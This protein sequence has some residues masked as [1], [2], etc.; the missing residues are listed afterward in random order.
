M[1]PIT[2]LAEKK[3]FIAFN[4]RFSVLA[5]LLGLI[6][7]P[8]A[9]FAMESIRVNYTVDYE[10]A[11]TRTLKIRA[12]I[13]GMPDEEIPLLLPD[14]RVT[15]LELFTGEEEDGKQTE[16][17]S[18]T[19]DAPLG[20]N[21][22]LRGNFSETV[23]VNY[24]IRLSDR[25]SSERHSYGDGRRCIIYAS[26]ILLGFGERE[27]RAGIF[28][29][30]PPAWIV[31]T[32]A[33]NKGK[34]IFVVGTRQ[35]IVFYLG[36][37]AGQQITVGQTEVSLAI[38][39]GWEAGREEILNSLRRQISYREKTSKDANI[40]PLFI[41]LLESTKKVGELKIVTLESSSGFVASASPS[42]LTAV[43]FEEKFEREASKSLIQCFFPSLRNPKVGTAESLILEYLLLKT[44]VKM[45]VLSKEQFLQKIAVGFGMMSEEDNRS[46]K[47]LNALPPKTLARVALSKEE[48]LSNLFLMDLLLGFYGRSTSSLEQLIHSK[49]NSVLFEK[50]VE[51][52]PPRTLFRDSGFLIQQRIVFPKGEVEDIASRLKPFGLVFEKR[53]LADLSFDLNENFQIER[54]KKKREGDGR[55][56]LVGDKIIAIDNQRILR[57]VDLIFCRSEMRPGEEITLL[58]ERN[59]GVQKIKQRV[60][61]EMFVR[62]EPNRLSDLDKQEKLE[63]FWSREVDQ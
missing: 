47:R 24:Q 41:A 8:P 62:L 45:G 50:L 54:I 34:G 46:L 22:L 49:V 18:E 44:D 16:T 10:D 43:E 7:S 30:L 42:Y 2:L 55:T 13:Q 21:I 59:G 26:D 58:I 27:T 4:L 32:N 15:G 12:K 31:V 33:K 17:L 40:E 57:P 51:G 29:E 23:S 19:S 3:R 6:L 20:R 53:E 39:P 61:S 11:A 25:F 52:D 1:N 63:V 35:D 28:F 5:F 38:E 48:K 37:G 60:G 56:L 14:S 36:A 9:S